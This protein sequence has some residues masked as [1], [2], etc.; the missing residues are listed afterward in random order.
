MDSSSITHSST[1]L[2]YIGYFTSIFHRFKLIPVL[3]YLNYRKVGH[4]KNDPYNHN[5]ACAT[6]EAFIF[7]FQPL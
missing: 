4:S 3:F 5:S 7:N 6:T 2:L 1:R